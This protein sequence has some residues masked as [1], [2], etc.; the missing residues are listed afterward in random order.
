ANPLV[1]EIATLPAEVRDR[2]LRP[3]FPPPGRRPGDGSPPPRPAP[4]TPASATPSESAAGTPGEP[5]RR[6]WGRFFP[7]RALM[8]TTNP[9]QYWLLASG[10]VDNPMAGD[11]MRIIVVG[12]SSSISAGGLIFDAKPWIALGLGMFVFSLL[13]WLP[14]V[15]GITRTLGRMMQ[16]TRQMESRLCDVRRNLRRADEIGSLCES[17]D[18]MAARLDGLVQGQK[19]FLGDIAHEL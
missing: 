10:R 5:P 7:L 14:P 19:R 12:R 16:A 13:F 17:I 15:S 11:P 2:I 1:G 6:R 18:Q 3:G 8:R 4:P 9:H